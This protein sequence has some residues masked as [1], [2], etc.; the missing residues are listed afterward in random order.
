M[1]D[2]EQY[3]T[4]LNGIK[5]ANTFRKQ[6]REGNTEF[7]THL[8][9][10]TEHCVF[11]QTSFRPSGCTP[12]ISDWLVNERLCYRDEKGTNRTAVC[13]NTPS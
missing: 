4:L 10:M 6:G 5:Q 7:Q 11:N 1:T 2:C 12:A 3:H 8:D 13:E 9:T